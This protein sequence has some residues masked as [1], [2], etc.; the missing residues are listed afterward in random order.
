MRN[1]GG[2]RVSDSTP[3]YRLEYPSRCVRIYIFF[4]SIHGDV[5][6]RSSHPDCN[7]TH[8]DNLGALDHQVNAISTASVWLL[9]Y[10]EAWVALFHEER[11]NAN[12]SI[13]SRLRGGLLYGYSLIRPPPPFSTPIRSLRLCYASIALQLAT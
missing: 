12:V 3:P 11:T 5:Y 7:L 2:H 9:D 10:N 13:G 6:V 1:L 8:Y 4:D